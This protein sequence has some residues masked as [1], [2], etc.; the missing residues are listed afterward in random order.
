[1]QSI[2]PVAYFAQMVSLLAMLTIG[3]F[4]NDTAYLLTMGILAIG[5]VIGTI[6][7]IR[8]A[9]RDAQRQASK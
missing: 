6:A 2:Y 9:R 5:G 1:M 4:S 7:L 8:D 3:K